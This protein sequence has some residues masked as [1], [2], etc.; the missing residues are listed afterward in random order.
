MQGGLKERMRWTTSGESHGYGIVTIFE[1][2]P[3][4]LAIDE[5]YI[6]EELRYRRIL[7]GRGPRSKIEQDRVKI[8]GGVIGGLTIGAPISVLVIN[9]EYELYRESLYGKTDIDRDKARL[10]PLLKPRP[11]HADLVGYAKYRYRSLRDVIER[12][13]ARETVGRVVVGAFCKKLLKEVSGTEIISHTISIGKHT[14]KS[15]YREIDADHSKEFIR[16]VREN[17]MRVY[18]D[19]ESE[20]AL[21][22]L[23]VEAK[24]RGDTLGGSTEILLFNPPRY[25]GTYV[26]HEKRLDAMFAGALLSIPSVKAIRIGDDIFN[27][28]GSSAHDTPYLSADGVKYRT[29]RCGGIEGGVSNGNTI[30]IT[31]HCKPLP[32]LFPGSK[33]F[34][35]KTGE[36][37]KS[38]T[39]RSD[40]CTVTTVGVIA[41]SMCAITTVKA[42]LRRYGEEHVEIVKRGFKLFNSFPD[43][44]H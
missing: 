6:V 32:T 30:R 4:G 43:I 16:K 44:P 21:Q 41:E 14:V 39:Q 3:A 19:N 27:I 37:D 38:I 40:T 35:V 18:A 13:S 29:N 31:V 22:R 8:I 36:I 42:L 24:K 26:H 23:I 11:G 17:P 9:T 20:E 2:F 12:S 33:S 34:N 5:S 15:R 1:G 7:F 28:N 10:K 25:I